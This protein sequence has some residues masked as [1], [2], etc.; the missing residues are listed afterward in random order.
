[1][2]KIQDLIKKMMEDLKAARKEKSENS[3]SK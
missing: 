3:Q 1:M 2:P